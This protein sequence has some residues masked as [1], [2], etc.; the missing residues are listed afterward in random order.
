MRS[1]AARSSRAER[2]RR[3][4]HCRAC[5]WHAEAS[6]GLAA[7]EFLGRVLLLARRDG[8]APRGAWVAPPPER[9]ANSKKQARETPR[10]A[11]TVPDSSTLPSFEA[12]LSRSA[13]GHAAEQHPAQGLRPRGTLPGTAV[14]G[15][16]G[17]PVAAPPAAPER[18]RWPSGPS[19]SSGIE[20]CNRGF[21]TGDK[22]GVVLRFTR[23]APTRI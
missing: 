16:S 3:F 4:A 8:G 19:S 20:E 23:T 11:I 22:S 9:S 15:L 21:R 12:P 5:I 13:S 18:F 17:R 2:F 7:R 6:R 1:S 14:A 10:A